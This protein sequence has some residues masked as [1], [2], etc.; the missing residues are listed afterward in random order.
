ML[1]KSYCFKNQTI[2]FTRIDT[3]CCAIPSSLLATHTYTPL[4]RGESLSTF[5]ESMLE[6]SLL[7]LFIVS[8]VLPLCRSAISGVG[9]PFA[10]QWISNGLFCSNVLFWVS[11]LTTNGGTKTKRKKLTNIWSKSYVA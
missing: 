3:F 5:H 11:K 2:P 1:S 7:L 8:S 6:Y 10:M 4:S 9:E